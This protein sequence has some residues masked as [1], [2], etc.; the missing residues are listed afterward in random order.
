MG[1]FNKDN[2][3]KSSLRFSEIFNSSPETI[4][5]RATCVRNLLYVI[6]IFF[7]HRDL[8]TT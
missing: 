5:L 3:H 6:A 8:C 1:K 7:F 2:S 4:T